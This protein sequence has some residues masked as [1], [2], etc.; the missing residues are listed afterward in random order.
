MVDLMR[1]W[2]LFC[3]YHRHRAHRDVVEETEKVVS[4]DDV[5]VNNFFHLGLS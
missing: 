1:W 3:Y 2:R 4:V 5:L